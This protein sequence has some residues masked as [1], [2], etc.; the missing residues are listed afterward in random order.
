LSSDVG[1]LQVYTPY[2]DDSHEDLPLDLARRPEV[3]FWSGQETDFAN[4]TGMSAFGTP[5]DVRGE[6]IRRM[7]ECGF[8]RIYALYNNIDNANANFFRCLL[9]FSMDLLVNSTILIN[10]ILLENNFLSFFM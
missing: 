8:I 5:R 4:Q 3:P 7:W 2:V 9:S 1:F 10:G 6:Y